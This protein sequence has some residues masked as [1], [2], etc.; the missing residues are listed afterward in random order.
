MFILHVI[1]M[2]QEAKIHVRR[3]VSTIFNLTLRFIEWF[4]PLQTYVTTSKLHSKAIPW[5]PV[6]V[7]SV[8]RCRGSHISYT[9]NS[10]MAVRLQVLRAGRPLTSGRFLILVSVR[11]WVNTSA[12]VRLEGLGKLN[13]FND[14]T[15]IRNQDIPACS[16]ETRPTTLSRPPLAHLPYLYL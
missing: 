13:K 3:S 12:I 2:R 11:G 16:T 9:T 1:F 15:G 7:Y 14:I 10:Q 4:W 8:M 5:Q 6:E